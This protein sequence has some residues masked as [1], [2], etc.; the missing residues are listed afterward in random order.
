M[1]FGEGEMI[2]GL[3]SEVRDVTDFGLFSNYLQQKTSGSTD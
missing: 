3:E 2:H 1:Q